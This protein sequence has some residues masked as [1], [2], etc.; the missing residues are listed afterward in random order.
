MA[1]NTDDIKSYIYDPTGMQKYV[2]DELDTASEGKYSV[3]DVTNPF[4]VAVETAVTCA[5]AALH[6]TS[7]QIRKQYPSLAT[8]EDDLFHHITD[9]ESTS[10]FATPAEVKLRFA[11]NAVDMKNYGVEAEDGSYREIVIPSGTVI[12]ALDTNMT[13]LNDI[14]VRLYSNNEV[15]VEQQLDNSNDLAYNDVSILGASLM[16]DAGNATWIYFDT[17]VKQLTKKTINQAISKSSGFSKLVNLDDSFCH[18]NV[19]YSNSTTSGYSAITKMFNDEYID[20]LSA[21]VVVK[22]YNGAVLFKIPDQYIMEGYISGTVKV[23]LYETKGKQY[24]PLNKY[25]YSD[26]SYKL[27]DT[28]KSSQ[29]AASANVAIMI[30]AMTIMDG[31]TDAMSVSDLRDNII[32][33]TTGDIDLPITEK[34]IEQY[35]NLNGY[36]IIK[37]L[38][39]VTEREF[40]GLKSIPEVSNNLIF[41]Q[42][43]V[44]FNTAKIVVNDLV[45][46]DNIIITNDRF[47]IKSNTIFKNENSIFRILSNNELE[48]LKNLNNFGLVSHLKK[49]KLFFNPFY[50]VIEKSESFINSRVYDLDNPTINHTMIKEKNISMLQRANIKKYT[51]KKT[52]NG[53]KLYVNLATNESFDKLEKRNIILQI[54]IPLYGGKSYAYIDGEYDSIKDYYSFNIDTNLSISEDETIDLKNGRSAISTKEFSLTT[55]IDLY[56]CTTDVNVADPVNFLRSDVDIS[57]YN[58]VVFTKE[59]INVT[60]G[61]ELKYIY[62]NLYNTYGERKYRTYAEDIPMVYKEDVYE[63]DPTTGGIVSVVKVDG[64]DKIK[65]NLV[66]SAGD[67]ILDD[68]GEPVYLHRKGETVTDENGNPVVD[69]DVGVIRY[70]DI[71]M[72]EYEFLACTSNAYNNYNKL[73]IENLKYYILEELEEINAKL[74]EKT[75]IKFKSFNTVGNLAIKS[76]NTTMYIDNNCSPKVTLYVQNVSLI[77]TTTKESY[78]TT[79]GTIFNQYFDKSKIVLEDIKS[80]IK[81]KLGSTIS[82]VKITG[83]DSLNSEIINIKDTTNR[84][85]LNKIMETN[86]N[87]ELVVKYDLDLDIIYI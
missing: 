35:G 80:S 47:I 84:L 61:K 67:P 23:D 13:L 21:S 56:I 85:Y 76:N 28:G 51:I 38:D 49:N 22:I 40:L 68:Q 20:P 32:N 3:V 48:Y 30:S 31:G 73:T 18:A 87:N 77:N 52:D 27:G 74:L 59:T 53:Y 9:N 86:K 78:K 6:E 72:M 81:N 5:A 15:F 62:N 36:T 37:N 83:V 17:W 71:L 75:S 79:I 34:Q 25:Q 46:L 55:N 63:V 7:N 45:G 4:V 41:A 65:Y 26:F 1:I 39:I 2:L 24:L 58:V 29:T 69:L 8:M 10:M 64:E 42:H 33:N 60:F 43:T 12:T 44:F 82:G 54:K 19:Y 57:T 16:T 14:L 66:H 70:I 11:V 50:Y